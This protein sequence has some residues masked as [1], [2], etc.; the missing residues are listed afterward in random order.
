MGDD[1]L[2]LKLWAKLN[3]LACLS[4]YLNIAG[5]RQSPEKNVLGILESPKKVLEKS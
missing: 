1:P 5:L 4:V 3:P 2:Y